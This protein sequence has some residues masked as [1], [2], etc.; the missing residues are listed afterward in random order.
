MR[1]RWFPLLAFVPLACVD[2]DV[3]ATT[4]SLQAQASIV[5]RW[6]ETLPP[7]GA[8][9]SIASD[10]EAANGRVF[11]SGWVQSAAAG[12][13]W[14]VRAYDAGSGAV[15]WTDRVSS[16]RR[17]AFAQA[18]I[19]TDDRVVTTG[20][21]RSPTSTD[22]LVRG[23]DAATGAL[24][25]S[26]TRDRGGFD[27]A[28]VVARD[29]GVAYVAGFSSA[30][31]DR[32]ELVA[33]D[34]D[35]GAVRWSRSDVLVG[36]WVDEVTGIAVA[37]GTVAIVGGVMDPDTFDI[38]AFVRVHAARDGAPLW[39]DELGRGPRDL[40]ANV[41]VHDGAVVVAG[42][43]GDCIAACNALAR[44]YD[45][46]TG[47]LLW[48]DVADDPDEDSMTGALA[49]DSD[50]VIVAGWLGHFSTGTYQA[51]VRSYDRD[52]FRWERLLD[53]ELADAVDAGG[54]AVVAGTGFFL[55]GG[56][57]LVELDAATGDTTAQSAELPT[58]AYRLVHA[59]NRSFA[60][61]WSPGTDGELVWTV[62][63]FKHTH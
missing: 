38:D 23:Y 33:Y 34:L 32:I 5:E 57:V 31:D 39:S 44:A 42:G 17:Q 63:G 37:D 7:E 18:T 3:D 27:A 53:R 11:A 43:L 49:I 61:G 10:V 13:E 62:H 26:D 1:Y 4:S 15:L 9:E 29:A 16:P 51:L 59:G 6:K 25:W 56:T 8:F 48:E 58:S 47:G 28:R 41:G 52:G 45:A 20:V 46:A 21:I 36:R 2:V 50:R 12:F 54:G 14:S 19:A 22:W 40:F 35:T 24:R 55:G 30:V 60:G